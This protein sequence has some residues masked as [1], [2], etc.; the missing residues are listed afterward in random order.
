VKKCLDHKVGVQD[1]EVDRRKTTDLVVENDCLT[2][3]QNEDAV[4]RSNWKNLV[5]DIE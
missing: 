3:Q 5:K 4:G 2:Q 1:L